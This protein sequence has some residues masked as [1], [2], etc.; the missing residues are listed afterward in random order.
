MVWRAPTGAVD[1]RRAAHAMVDESLDAM[2][3][4]LEPNVI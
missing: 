3:E 1:K 2:T 4:L